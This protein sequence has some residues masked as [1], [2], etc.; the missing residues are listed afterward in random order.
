MPET[1]ARERNWFCAMGK[2]NATGAYHPHTSLVHAS[3]L[4]YANAQPEAKR[5]RMLSEG[6]RLILEQ[7]AA[8][9][10]PGRQRMRLHQT[11]A[12]RVAGIDPRAA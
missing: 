9:N 10:V 4:A 1:W 7:E 5:N 3:L 11:D 12:M 2:S 6:K 8:S